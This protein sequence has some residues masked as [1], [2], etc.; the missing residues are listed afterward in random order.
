MWLYWRELGCLEVN[1][2]T[3]P[4]SEKI[5]NFDGEQKGCKKVLLMN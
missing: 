1:C 4:F 2:E 3:S 5:E